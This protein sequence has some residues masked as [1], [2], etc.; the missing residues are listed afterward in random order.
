MCPACIARLVSHTRLRSLIVKLEGFND[1]DGDLDG[2]RDMLRAVEEQNH[3]ATFWSTRMDW[4]EVL[5]TWGL[6][7]PKEWP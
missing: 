1:P 7:D 5:E 2:A 3:D 6:T 4:Y